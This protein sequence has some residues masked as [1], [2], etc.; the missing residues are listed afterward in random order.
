MTE[1][2]FTVV[3]A[4]TDKA[5]AGNPAAV[6]VLDRFYDDATLLKIAQEHNLSETAFLVQREHAY[7]D[8]RWFTPGGEVPLCGH[9]TLASGFA[10]FT[11]HGIEAESIRFETKSGTLAVGRKG[12][13]YSLDLPANMPKKVEN[14]PSLADAIG[15]EPLEV[16]EGQ[17]WLA[18]LPTEED[19]RAVRPNMV[20]IEALPVPE[21]GITA[22]GKK[23]D[24]VSRLFA[25]KLGIPEDPFTGSLHAMLVPYWS[26]KLGKTEITAHQASARGGDASCLLSGDRVFLFGNAV[27]TMR[28]TMVF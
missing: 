19:V 11:E 22:P 26:K 10:L 16:L 6:M 18:V 1:H 23:T 2:E 14:P 17:F 25:P 15:T 8:L 12:E 20:A 28:G 3:D 7:Y 4:F 13:S 9:A 27:V 24:I 21:L 5:F